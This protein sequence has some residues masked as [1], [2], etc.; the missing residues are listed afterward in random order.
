MRSISTCS[1]S[2]QPACVSWGTAV[3]S[4]QNGQT[5]GVGMAGMLD[6]TFGTSQGHLSHCKNGTTGQGYASARN[7]AGIPSVSG[8]TR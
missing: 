2:M 7:N 3:A 5:R 8:V 6:W 1:A 4:P